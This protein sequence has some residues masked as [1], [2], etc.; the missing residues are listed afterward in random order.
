M[1]TTTPCP[2]E[3]SSP[4]QRERRGRRCALKRASPSIAARMVGIQAMLEAEQ[5]DDRDE[6]Q[7]VGGKF[8]H[9]DRKSSSRGTPTSGI[10]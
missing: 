7:P 6:R 4:D 10:P 9:L 8:V 2:A 3:K 5:E 1:V